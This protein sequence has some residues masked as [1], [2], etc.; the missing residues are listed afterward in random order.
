MA[1]QRV[2]GRKQDR[3]LQARRVHTEIQS[4]ESTKISVKC[5]STA[6][7]P[8]PLAFVVYIIY[9]RPN[10]CCTNDVSISAQ[11]FQTIEP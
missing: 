2:Y 8:V 1:M 11:L 6:V 10:F 9:F 5:L 3:N 7:S 4:Q